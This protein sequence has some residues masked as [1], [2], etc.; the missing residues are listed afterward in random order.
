MISL[1]RAPQSPPPHT[2]HPPPPTP[3]PPAPPK[4]IYSVFSRFTDGFER[5]IDHIPQPQF[6][7]SFV[8]TNGFITVLRCIEYR[9][10]PIPWSQKKPRNRRDDAIFVNHCAAGDRRWRRGMDRERNA[11][12]K[13]PKLIPPKMMPGQDR[14]NGVRRAPRASCRNQV[15]PLGWARAISASDIS[16]L[17]YTCATQPQHR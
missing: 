6:D 2:P 10:I 8:T 17:R 12:F 1:S 7:D 14:N 9:T 11:G 13:K 4:L 3:H 5:Y 16:R 15:L